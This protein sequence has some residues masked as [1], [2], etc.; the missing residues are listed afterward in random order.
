MECIIQASVTDVFLFIC[1][2]SLDV[3]LE[4]CIQLNE[5]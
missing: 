5:T 1:V 3:M 2:F 4:P